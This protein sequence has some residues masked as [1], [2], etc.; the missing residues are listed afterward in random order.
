MVRCWQAAGRTSAIGFSPDS[1]TIS[2]PARTRAISA[3]KSLAASASEMWVVAVRVWYCGIVGAGSGL[4]GMDC[5]RLEC[6]GWQAG[7]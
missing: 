3:G 6:D 4:G 5:G 7:L 2:S 1:M